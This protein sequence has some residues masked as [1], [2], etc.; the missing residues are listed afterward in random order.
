MPPLEA[1]DTYSESYSPESSPTDE[2][3]ANA[4][5]A[6]AT[7]TSDPKQMDFEQLQAHIKTQRLKKAI[8]ERVLNQQTATME[9]IILDD[10][11][12][13]LEAKNA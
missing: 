6:A 11:I 10:E 3:V 8:L 5:E 2:E 4:T 1:D 13:D 12:Q 9:S 7:T